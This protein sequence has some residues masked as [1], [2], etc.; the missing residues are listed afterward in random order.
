MVSYKDK[1]VDV[2]KISYFIA[3][4]ITIPSLAYIYLN[5]QKNIHI[6]SYLD[7]KTQQ[8]KSGYSVLYQ[9]HKTLAEMIFTTR[10]DRVEVIDIFKDATLGTENQKNIARKNLYS[11]LQNTYNLLK[12]FNIKQLHFHL[13]NNDS[14]LRFHRPK[15]FG[16]NLTGIRST[17]EYVNKNHKMIDGFE[18][19]RIYN[20]YRFVYPLF[21]EGTYIGS[22]EVSFSTLAMNLKY[23]NDYNVVSNFLIRKGVVNAKVFEDEKSNYTESRLENFYIEKATI[24]QIKAAKKIKTKMPLSKTTIDLVQ[25][26]KDSTLSFSLYDTKRKEIMTFIKV[27]NPVTKKVVGLFVVRSNAQYIFDQIHDFEMKML[28]GIFF[29]GFMLLYVYRE[30]RYREK[31]EESRQKILL[32]NQTLEEKVA[33]QVKEIKESNLFHETIFNTVNDGMAILDLESNFILVNDAYVKMTGYTKEELYSKSCIS[34]TTENMVER[35]KEVVLEVVEKGYYENYEKRCIISNQKELEVKMDIV[36]M[37]NKTQLLIAVKDMT[38]ENKLKSDK[39]LQEQQLLQQSR[40][41]QM[42]EMISMIAHQWRQPLAAIAATVINLDLKFELAMFDLDTKE[43]REQQELYFRDNLKNISSYVQ[44]LS[45]TIDDF[46]NFYKSNKQIQL[47]SLE[48]VTKRA[49]KIIQASL[50]NDGIVFVFNYNSDEKFEMY[51]NEIMQVILNILKNAQDNLL[52][53]EI[54]DGKITITTYERSISFCDNGGGIE[55][56]I[57]DKIFDPYFSTKSELNGT[58]LGLYMSKTIIQEH[59]N[60]ALEVQNIGKGVCFTISFDG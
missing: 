33:Q 52:E 58:G 32:F 23:M 9:E 46:R 41:A 60:G 30:S 7:K 10:I 29:I 13:P 51:E 44:G 5:Y 50:E 15:K 31:I 12:K 22:V 3:L 2:K 26:R 6:K 37:P 25:E 47:S 24:K 11:Y 35:S 14:F 40:M 42:G 56:D 34:L 21:Y 43:G 54:K 39:K 17:V 49:L 38:I 55:A 20:G 16:D 1:D 8:Y 57:I 19:G 18:E 36:L 45:T 4:F 28:V 59:H 27:Q 48:L 53:R